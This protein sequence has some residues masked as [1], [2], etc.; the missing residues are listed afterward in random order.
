MHNK[1]CKYTVHAFKSA[2]SSALMKNTWV[3]HSKR[4]GCHLSTR[5]R[6]SLNYRSSPVANKST[7]GLN[8]MLDTVQEKVSEC[9]PADGRTP[10]LH[11]PVVLWYI[12]NIDTVMWDNYIWHLDLHIHFY[13]GLGIISYKLL[14][15]HRSH[16]WPLTV[17]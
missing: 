16:S 13:L 11:K 14:H 2:K 3:M 17:D 15:S 4:T 8:K 1:Y 7:C 6:T 5:R 10:C 12:L 9:T